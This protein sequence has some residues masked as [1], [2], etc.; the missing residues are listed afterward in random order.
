MNKNSRWQA[1]VYVLIGA[2]SYGVLS[3]VVKLAYADGFSAGEVTGSQVLTGCVAMWLLSI[4]YWKLCRQLSLATLAK[5][6]G[7]GTFTGLTGIF[8]Y[9]SLQKLDASFA[10]LLLFQFAW[11]GLAVEWLFHRKR[12]GRMQV[13]GAIVVGAGTLLASGLL[14][15]GGARSYDPA[16]IALGLLAAVCYTLFVYF[17]GRVAT[18]VPA[19]LRSAWMLTGAAIITLL[20]FPPRFIWNGAVAEGLWLWALILGLFGMILPPYL[21]AKGAPRLNTGLTAI[22]GSVE[23]PVVMICSAW[24]LQERAEAAQWLG[25]VLILAGIGV[26]EWKGR[27]SARKARHTV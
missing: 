25:V 23:L 17:S 21:F 12:P 13:I 1:V 27:A 5:M 26:S 2:A 11:M 22:L 7:S 6:V 9:Q 14:L 20:I 18:S 10:V 19:T 4:P 15:E 16:G 24:L 8:Y 3:S